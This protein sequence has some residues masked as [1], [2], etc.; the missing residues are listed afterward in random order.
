MTTKFPSAI[1]RD[2]A[3][4]GSGPIRNKPSAADVAMMNAEQY[5]KY[6]ESRGQWP[7]AEQKAAMRN[8]L[9][10]QINGGE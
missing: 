6:A 3:N 8:R 2:Q 4:G 7:T 5:Q 9:L 10:P 1:T